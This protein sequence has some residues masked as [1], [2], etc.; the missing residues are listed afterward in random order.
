MR[1]DDDDDPAAEYMQQP[2]RVA[3]RAVKLKVH[4]YRRVVFS[5]LCLTSNIQYG[6]NMSSVSIDEARK[7]K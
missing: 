3:E 5:L 6:Y 2:L 1:C 4:N 7:V